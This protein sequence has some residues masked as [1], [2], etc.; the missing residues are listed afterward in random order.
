M[1]W[2]LELDAATG[3]ARRPIPLAHRAEGRVYPKSPANSDL[4]VVE[5]LDLIPGATTMV[6]TRAFVVSQQWV[7]DQEEATTYAAPDEAGDFLFD[8]DPAAFEDP[9]AEVNAYYQVTRI[10]RWFEEHVGLS[11]ELPARVLV[12]YAQEPGGQYLN[13]YAY[14]DPNSGRF[15]VVAGQAGEY[16]FAYDGMTLAHEF[17]HPVFDLRNDIADNNLYPINTD[18]QGFHPAPQGMNEGASDYWAATSFD[19][20]DVFAF[21]PED[22]G[23]AVLSPR[24]VDNAMRC[25]DDVWG[26]AHLDAPLVSG[27]FW[28]VREALGAQA[29]DEVVYAAL[30][31]V[32]DSP[33]FEEL[34]GWL[35]ADAHTLAE[36]GVVAD[37]AAAAVDAALEARGVVD[38]G[39]TLDLR[40]GAPRT[41]HLIGADMVALAMG[42][43]GDICPLL[44]N[45]EI[46]LPPAF[47]FRVEAPPSPADLPSGATLDGLRI[48]SEVTRADGAPL[49]EDDVLFRV[50]LRHGEPVTYKLLDI[51]WGEDVFQVPIGPQDFDLDYAESPAEIFIPASK[52]SLPG[53][54]G[55]AAGAD[56]DGGYDDAPWYVALLATNCPTVSHTLTATWVV[57]EPPPPEPEPDADVAGAAEAG[58][59]AG[60]ATADA[61]VGGDASPGSAPDGGCQ[62][63]AAPSPPVGL[64]WL[65]LLALLVLRR[66]G[67]GRA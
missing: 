27:T 8:P 41:V 48:T 9:F 49:G 30:G 66:R 4:A 34:A 58:E 20:P 50:L 19:D 2:R 42:A 26:E 47:S 28:A 56:G 15:M 24:A 40:D 10:S 43:S 45:A 51:P 36:Q 16:D 33:T 22:Q 64:A 21:F 6:G 18:A 29:G 11:L 57:T 23:Q 61:G 65:A 12:N 5:L 39:R 62:G 60:G 31:Q 37:A 25:P 55:D 7:D 14:T 13:A 63:A 67:A 35:A 38:C 46:Q 32:S 53:W 52:L 59:D 1:A 54:S 17:G 44:R 3:R